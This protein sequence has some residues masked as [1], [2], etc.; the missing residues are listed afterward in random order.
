MNEPPT[1]NALLRCLAPFH[2]LLAGTY[3]LGLQI[4]GSDIDLLC[5]IPSL[6]RFE[7]FLDAHGALFGRAT[8]RRAAH[9]RPPA[10]VVSLELSGLEVEIFAQALPTHQQHGFRHM[11]VEGRLL[12]LGGPALARAIV[13]LKRRGRKTEPAFAEALGL[14]GDPYAAVL[15]LESAPLEALEALVAP[16]TEPAPP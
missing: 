3:P 13:D 8:R 7:A 10:L 9:C 16:F 11:V 6:E 1:L 5:E 14:S 2:P 12:A 15:D 4:E